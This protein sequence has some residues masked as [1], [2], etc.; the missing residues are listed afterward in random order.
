MTRTTAASGR[1]KEFEEE[2]QQGVRGVYLYTTLND[3]VVLG[4]KKTVQW[5]VFREGVD[6]SFL[7]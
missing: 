4:V 7:A 3:H 2:L 1:R 6:A 5:T